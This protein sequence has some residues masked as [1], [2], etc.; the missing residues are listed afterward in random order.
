VGLFIALHDKLGVAVETEITK[1]SVRRQITNL[2]SLL[3]IGI[4]SGALLTGYF[5]YYYNPSGRYR[6]GH[7]LL[8]PSLVR[9]LSF[10][11]NVGERGQGV[12]YVFDSIMFSRYDP[13]LRRD[14]QH[15]LT[16]EQYATLYGWLADDIS[17]DTV[18]EIAMA[19]FDI[20]GAIS[21]TLKVH[22]EHAR[23]SLP[24][25]SIFQAVT[26][27]AKD[28]Y[29]RIQL[30]TASNTSYAYFRHPGMWQQALTLAQLQP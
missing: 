30:H 20:A 1:P 2:V 19:S 26:L 9:G 4:L 15:P 12:H 14:I 25:T 5:L 21:V 23:D 8:E 10:T 6:A 27:A 7:V 18:D 22:P 13:E 17:L 24:S 11:E 16:L 28:D 3:I 29:Y